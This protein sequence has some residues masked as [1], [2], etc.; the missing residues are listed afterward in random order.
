M[1]LG[2]FSGMHKKSL[3]NLDQCGEKRQSVVTFEP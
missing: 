1:E 3:I 2:V